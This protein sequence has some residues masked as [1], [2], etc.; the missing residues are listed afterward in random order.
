MK[1]ENQN[2][3]GDKCIKDDDEG[4]QHFYDISKLAT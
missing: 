4:N 1:S 3:I 2:I